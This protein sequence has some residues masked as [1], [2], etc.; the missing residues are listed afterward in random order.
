MEYKQG[1]RRVQ[2]SML[3]DHW[4]RLARQQRLIINSGHRLQ[5]LSAGQLNTRE[6]P[7]FQH[8]RFILDGVLCQGAVEI[9]RSEAEWYAHGH[10]LDGRYADVQ[11][12]MVA[13]GSAAEG[14]RH[15][16]P[17][18]SIPTMI[19]PA[20]A[21]APAPPCRPGRAVDEERWRELAWQRLQLRLRGLR[22]AAC[23]E[24][25][26]FYRQLLR[27]LGYGGNSDA[28]E[29]LA[30][31]VP[32]RQAQALRHRPAALRAVYREQAAT[33]PW[34]RGGLRPFNR[35]GA[36]LDLIAHWMIRYGLPEL[37]KRTSLLIQS[38]RSLSVLLSSL[39]L[40]LRPPA[41]PGMPRLGRGRLIEMLGNLF[42]PLEYARAVDS[43]GYRFY[44]R[45]LFFGLPQPAVYGV[46]RH[47]AAF[48]SYLPLRRFYKSQALLQVWRHYCEAGA[49]HAC[50]LGRRPS[51]A[52]RPALLARPS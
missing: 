45:E 20:S 50:P 43:E 26:V 16:R 1:G 17:G 18:R 48:K 9:H 46:F 3:Y 27:A 25:D 4:L 51:D 11:L 28:F 29:I 40:L 39:E 37:Y 41:V 8:A 31:R 36:G 19:L 52:F 44:L 22:A 10:H 5:L 7:D 6:G 49:C 14:V 42:I 2:E 30:R 21:A 47:H 13:A 38:R 12:H 34:R 24:E 15:N 35:V 32:W 23:A 33:L